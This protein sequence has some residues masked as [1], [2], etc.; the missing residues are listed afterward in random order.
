GLLALAAGRPLTAKDF[1]AVPE[2]AD[3]VLAATVDLPKILGTTRK[4]IAGA[5]EQ[6]KE[7][8]EQIL[9]QL[10]KELKLSFE[11]ELFKAFGQTWV[12][13]DSPSNGGILM[14]APILSLEVTD[15]EL[16]KG[17]FEKLMEVLKLAVPGELNPGRFG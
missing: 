13:Y 10:E 5:G 15:Y 2:D 3:L 16:A 12:L 6:P 17:T 9:G 8:F 11:E 7:N 4:L 14:T 1:G